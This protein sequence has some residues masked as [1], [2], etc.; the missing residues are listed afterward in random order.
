[1]NVYFIINL[2]VLILSLEMCVYLVWMKY[3]FR[4]YGVFWV[5]CNKILNARGMRYT[6]IITYLFYY[7]LHL[8]KCYYFRI[9]IFR[10]GG[11]I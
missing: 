10:N 6:L 1:M 7:Y 11:S 3:F 9:A 2:A 8:K 4:T 5:W